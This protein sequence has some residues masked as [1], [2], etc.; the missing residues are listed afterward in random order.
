MTA[1]FS[2]VEYLT[3]AEACRL[4]PGKP[5][6]SAL[7]RWYTRGSHGVVLKTIKVGRERFTTEAWLSEFVAASTAAANAKLVAND[8]EPGARP[9]HVAEQLQAAGVL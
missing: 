9:S 3:L 8:A 6:P 4:L 1:T 7:W 5:S 2:G